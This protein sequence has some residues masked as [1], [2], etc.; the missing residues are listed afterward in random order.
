MATDRATVLEAIR[1][2]ESAR[3]AWEMTVTMPTL[4]EGQNRTINL[5]REYADVLQELNAQREQ[6]ATVEAERDALREQVRALAA[7]RANNIQLTNEF[8]ACEPYLNMDIGETIVECV[9]RNRKDA[10]A[11]VG[12]LAKEKLRAEQA[13]TE[14][15]RLEARAT[16]LRVEAEAEARRLAPKRDQLTLPLEPQ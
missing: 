9:K 11:V 7:M 12:L 13:E 4:A 14:V 8:A 1:Q 5:L 2:L 16:A 3:D 6:V 15:A 10:V